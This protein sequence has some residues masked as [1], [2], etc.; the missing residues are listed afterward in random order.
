MTFH[1]SY[2]SYFCFL[3]C[4]FRIFLITCHFV[5]SKIR[6]N[7]RYN[8]ATTVTQN[9]RNMKTIFFYFCFPVIFMGI[10]TYFY[11]NPPIVIYLL[12]IPYGLFTYYIRVKKQKKWK[13]DINTEIENITDSSLLKVIPMN[14]LCR[15]VAINGIGYIYPSKLIF[16][17]F[18]KDIRLEILFS[19]M[20]KVDFL[21]T[22]CFSYG[23]KIILK[24]N[25][26][27]KFIVERKEQKEIIECL[28]QQ[29]SKITSNIK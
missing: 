12:L 4:E 19:N 11:F 1:I 15:I 21:E 2:K 13:K 8:L 5:S 6:K 18:K 9:K 23:I 20:I 17:S 16:K 10:F 24:D 28:N 26:I 25:T 3:S 14:Y 22:G 27:K 29:L 7:T